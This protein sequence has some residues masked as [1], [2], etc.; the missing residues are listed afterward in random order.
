MDALLAAERSSDGWH[1]GVVM[2][3]ADAHPDPPAEIDAF[4][5]FEEAVHK[6]LASLLA[7]GDDIDSGVFLL[8]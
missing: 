5:L 1:L 3:V 6:V 4:D 8:L 2:V 7:V